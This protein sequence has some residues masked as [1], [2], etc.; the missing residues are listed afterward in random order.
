MNIWDSEDPEKAARR[1]LLFFL[2]LTLAVGA[3]A[4][5]FTTPQIPTWYAG[6]HKPSFTPPNWLFAPVWTTL[7]LAMGFAAWRVWKKTGLRSLEMV[8][9][10]LQLVL[11]FAWSGIFFALHKINA[12]LVEILMLDLTVFYTMLLFFRRDRLAGL[13]FLAY[14]AWL[15]YATA[16]NNGIWQLN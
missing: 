4:S 15:G 3:G 16:L 6:L 7:Y 2:V 5:L 14:L 10:G 11:N 1:P 12:A 8:A 13:V 9:F